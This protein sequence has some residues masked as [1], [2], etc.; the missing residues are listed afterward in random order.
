MVQK[1][2]PDFLSTPVIAAAAVNPI[3][4]YAT[5]EKDRWAVVGGGAAFRTCVSKLLWG[6]DTK[7]AD[8]ISGWDRYCNK[9]GIYDEGSDHIGLLTTMA[10]RNDAVGFFRHASDVSTLAADKV[11]AQV[12]IWLVSGFA[13]QGAAERH[14][15]CMADLHTR[16]RTRLDMAKAEAMIEVKMI[17]QYKLAV[18]R[19]SSR[20][21]RNGDVS[22]ARDLRSIYVHT[23]ARASEAREL[24]LRAAALQAQ[25]REEAE[26]ALEDEEPLV[27][28]EDAGD[29]LGMVEA[30][31]VVPDGF[32]IV[33]ASPT[34][35]Q[36]DPTNPASDALIEQRIMVRFEHYGWCVGTL[37]GKV[38]DGRRTIERD[39]VNIVAKFDVL[40]T[41]RRRTSRSSRRCTTARRRQST[42]RGCYS[43]LFWRRRR[44][45]PWQRRPAAQ[46]SPCEEVGPAGAGRWAVGCPGGWAVARSES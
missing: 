2:K 10:D 4:T 21:Q 18:A 14:N 39:R 38:N 25:A 44:R 16:K 31:L 34:E 36:L 40:T 11:F 6:E 3:Y 26:A 29:V 24:R 13:N 8:A 12:A 22:I 7:Q 15:K 20:E 1:R 42:S 28:F 43:S 32:K 19:A 41:A 37:T 45:R 30:P 35:E 33:A 23:R 27:T 17:T 5:L 9:V 46:S